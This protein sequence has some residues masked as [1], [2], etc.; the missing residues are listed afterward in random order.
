MLDFACQL[1][2][3]CLCAEVNAEVIARG[4]VGFTGAE[5]E[6]LVNQAALKAAIDNKSMVS[7][8]DL[9]FAKDK[10][11]MGEAA[12]RVHSYSCTEFTPRNLISHCL[13]LDDR[14]A[15][16]SMFLSRI[17]YFMSTVAR[18]AGPER[19][20]AE[21]DMNN[22]IITAYHEGGHAMVAYYTKHAMP[23]NKATIMPR[24]P[25]LGHVRQLCPTNL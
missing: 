12:G 21:I 24:G 25:T 22:K 19:R 4:T 14:D 6:N 16:I 7:F 17:R 15:A 2:G 3:I 18:R 11:L 9:E 8:V 20:S 1:P 23:I 13:G 10:I 5:L